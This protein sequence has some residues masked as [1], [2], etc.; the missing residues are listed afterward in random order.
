MARGS[1]KTELVRILEPYGL[2]HRDMIRLS[3]VLAA[4][5]V[6]LIDEA[7]DEGSR[8]A[9][10]AILSDLASSRTLDSLSALDNA[11]QRKAQDA[12]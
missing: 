1:V 3:K 6:E 7:L 5:F 4:Y 12:G 2:K 8:Y 11:Y 9:R 10:T